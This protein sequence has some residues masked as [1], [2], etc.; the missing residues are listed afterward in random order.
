MLRISDRKQFWSGLIFFSIGVIALWALPSHI[1]TAT[2]MGP[3]YFPMLLGLCLIL[4][5]TTSMVLGIRSAE[6]IPVRR[7]PLVALLSI[8]GG[9]L[10]FAGLITRVGLAVSL[11][12]VVLASCYGRLVDHSVEV[13]IIYAVLLGMTWLIFIYAIELPITLFW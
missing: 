4:F 13:L 2:A 10:I 12:C 8:I 3:G 1:G 5:G 11:L 9:V 6:Q 7:P